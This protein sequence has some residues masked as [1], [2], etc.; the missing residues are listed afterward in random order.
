MLKNGELFQQ[1]EIREH[2]ARGGSSDI[3]RAL[4][5]ATG[6]EVVLKIPDAAL[7][8]DPA[9]FE[10]FQRELGIL[11]RLRHPAIQK[12]IKPGQFGRIPFLVAEMVNGRSLREIIDRDAPLSPELAV[13]YI[14]KIADGV[15]YCH[16]QGV[17]HRDLK[18][19]NVL[20][21][22]EGQPVII[23]FGLAL[24]AGGRRVTYPNFSGM[25]GTPEYMAPEQVEGKRG[26]ARTDI[27]A[28]GV[29]LYEMLAGRPPFQADTPVATMGQHLYGKV[30]RLD[31]VRPEVGTPL[32]AVVG[33]C[34]QR[35]PEKRF[36]T[37]DEL[38]RALDH[39]EGVDPSI[40]DDAA[41]DAYPI[42]KNP[43]V[44]GIIAGVLVLAGLALLA[45]LL[46]QL[47]PH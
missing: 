6:V 23:D 45:L 20:V 43:Y 38:L 39:P 27:Y 47:R 5:T 41:E 8:G 2:L 28:L 14:R 22:S 29:I 33:K 12:G 26:D 35:D 32:A 13:A 1:Y 37:V 16:A 30:Q 25:A 44:V 9:Q 34:L 42:W 3:Y 4:D 24:T 36:A 11:N 40:L 19:E 31:R 10:R 7:I 21:T 17:I 46:Q 18:P 15:A